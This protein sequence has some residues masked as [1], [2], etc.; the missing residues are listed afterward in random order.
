MLHTTKHS[1]TTNIKFQDQYQR[2]GL[3]DRHV[4][5]VLLLSAIVI[6]CNRNS[7]LNQI[8]LSSKNQG[9]TQ[10]TELKI[11]WDKGYTLEEDEALQQVVSRWEQQTGNQVQLSHYNNDELSRKAQRAIQAGNPPDILMN[12]SAERVLNPRLA[13][14]GKLA[15]VSDIIE[16]IKHHYSDTILTDVYFYNNLKKEYSYYAIPIHQ[17]IP[18]IFYWRDLLKTSGYSEQDIPQDWH[19]FWEFWQEIHKTVPL[20]QKKVYGIGLPMSDRAGDTYEVFEQILE[21]YDVQLLDSQGQLRVDDPQIRQG[22]IQCIS[23]YTKFYRQ[24]YVPPEAI[25]WLNPDNN[26]SL[27]NRHIAMTPNNSLSIPA[28][29]RQA[30]DLYRNKLGTLRYPNKPSGKPMRYLTLVRQVVIFAESQN[31]ELAKDFITYLIQP[32]ISG[33]YLK[34]AGGRTLPVHKLVW[35]DPFWT[36]PAD[37]H[38]STAAQPLIK[39]QTRLFYTAQNPAYSVVLEE[40]IWGDAIHKVVADGV[41]PEQAAD[42][43][44][45]R[46][47][48]IFAEWK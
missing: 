24:G 30:P 43:A 7:D 44:I 9:L 25:N 22:I 11:W 1:Q 10:S 19:G 27:L 5:I 23:W 12:D 39:E 38:I 33:D 18:L 28:A 40:N 6:G 17:A 16:P 32:K 47:K 13:W 21:A 20:Q 42:E 37:P 31:L 2:W 8:A 4:L 29:V 48:Q 46:I 15:D 3:S 41:S 26:R 36:D 14:E 35:Q 34:A 45:A